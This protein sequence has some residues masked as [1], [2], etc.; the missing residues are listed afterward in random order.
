MSWREAYRWS[1]IAFTEVA[2]QAIYG[3]RQ[4]NVHPTGLSAGF[5]ARA[6]RR[7]RQ[8]KLLVAALLLL[9][10]AGGSSLL[11]AAPRVAAL[12]L[13]VPIAPAVFDLGVIAALLGID[14]AFLWWMGLQVL[15]SLLAAPILPVLE[16]LPAEPRTR[17]RAIALTFLRLFDLPLGAVVVGT[18][19]LVGAAL[20]PAAGLA[21]VPGGLVAGTFALALSL[22]TARS[23]QRRLQG[24]SRGAAG[25]V[26]RWTY[27]VL[28]VVPVFGLFGFVT[29]A[30]VFFGGLAGAAATAPSPAFAGLLA[31][32]PLSFAALPPLA[33]GGGS[34]LPLGAVG[35]A[36]L[37]VAAGGYGALAVV[38]AMRFAEQLGRLSVAPTIVAGAPPGRPFGLD[39]IG[40]ARA[41]LVKDLR[42][43]SR[44]P[45]FAFLLLLPILDSVALGLLSYLPRT[46]TGTAAD[47]ALGA[48]T[49]AA[50]LATFF[51]PAF[52]AVEVLA[53]AYGRTLPLADRSLVAGKVA[54]VGAVYL[55][56]AGVV[57]AFV[58]LRLAAPALFVGFVLAELPAVVA[59]AVLELG[60]VLRH[61]ERRGLPVVSLYAGSWTAIVVALPGLVVAVLPLA[62]YS[63]L[64]DRP[65][66]EALGAMALVAVAALAASLPLL[67]RRGR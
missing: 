46:P 29:L 6:R 43:A 64:A 14:V 16:A 20:G 27:L 58:D 35:A 48:V 4:G 54:L 10:T 56:A 19:L 47:L 45:G 33:A 26:L 13:P 50:L 7:V 49:S 3:F 36:T 63:A 32:F 55:V 30:P 28:W 52:F 61:A 41:V 18:P 17:R 39:R 11:R 5:V 66:I 40:P 34:A 44:T 15:P 25:L 9:V 12:L 59:A 53:Y 22:V 1:G 42:I 37:A 23:F 57:L 2:L 38:A 8:S 21:A 24:A 67:H 51:G 65:P 31:I 62:T 60:L